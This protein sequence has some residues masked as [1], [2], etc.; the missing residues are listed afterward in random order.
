LLNSEA[1]DD[2]EYVI[3]DAE[4]AVGQDGPIARYKVR[5]LVLR[6]RKTPRISDGDRMALLRK[7]YEL[8][9]KNI[10]VH[11][12]DKHSYRELCEVAVQLVQRRE[13]P[14]ILDE[15]IE[16]MRQA[17]DRILDPEMARQLRQYESIRAR[18][19]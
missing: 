12:W 19:N 5:L 2:T 16:Q 13:S 4:A 11:Q 10:D 1:L 14:Y 9:L 18:L 15:A 6:A 3:R 8:A 7:A 17:S